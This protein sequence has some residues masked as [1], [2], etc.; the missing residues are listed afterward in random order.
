MKRFISWLVVTITLLFADTAALYSKNGDVQI[1]HSKNF[2]KTIKD[3]DQLTLVEFFAP[4]CG[5]CKNLA[6]IYNKLATSLK[7][8]VN[9]A[10]IDC[11]EE[12]NKSVCGQ[13]GIQGFPTI[14][15]MRPKTNKAGGRSFS[16]EDYSGQRTVKAIAEHVTSIMPSKVRKINDEMLQALLNE[17]N[18]T[19]KVVLF[20]KKGATSSIFKALS[21]SFGDSFIFAQ[22]RDT[23]KAA[24]DHFGVKEFP[25]LL[26]LPGGTEAPISFS[27]EFKLPQLKKFLSTFVPTND[28]KSKT[29]PKVDAPESVP[30]GQYIHGMR[31]IANDKQDR[32]KLETL[33]LP[34]SG[35]W[36]P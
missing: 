19:A 12:S 20:S 18:E 2:Q 35:N 27:E 34:H 22:I 10:A 23:Q 28:G 30:Q 33:L 36:R 17:K 24:V 14:K 31:S 13:Y 8:M 11:D 21:T 25:S 3:S 4:W 6:P 5:H 15:V 1:L 9:V 16:V 26:I 29:K 32:T 7:D